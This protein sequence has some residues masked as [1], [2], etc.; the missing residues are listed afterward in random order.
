MTILIDLTVAGID[1]GSFDLYS[2]MYTSSG[3]SEI[4]LLVSQANETRNRTIVD[5]VIQA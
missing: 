4:K 1:T 5:G 3:N 2:D